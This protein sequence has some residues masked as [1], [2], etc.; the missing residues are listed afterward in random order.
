MGRRRGAT[1]FVLVEEEE[2]TQVSGVVVA[3]MCKKLEKS[4]ARL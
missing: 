4:G 3:S 2:V 1:R